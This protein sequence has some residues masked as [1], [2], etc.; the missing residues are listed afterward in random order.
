MTRTQQGGICPVGTTEGNCI[1]ATLSVAKSDDM[2]ES[3]GTW[4][5]FLK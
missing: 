2:V 1:L 3:I 5:G 4:E